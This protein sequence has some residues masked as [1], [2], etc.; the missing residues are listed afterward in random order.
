MKLA[1][2]VESNGESNRFMDSGQVGDLRFEAFL[3]KALTQLHVTSKTPGITPRTIS[4]NDKNDKGTIYAQTLFSHASH[5][6]R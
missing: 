4:N 5:I 1:N 6:N 3:G 2:V